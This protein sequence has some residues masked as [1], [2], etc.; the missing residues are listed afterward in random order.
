[1][2]N[3]YYRIFDIHM[4]HEVGQVQYYVCHIIVNGWTDAP[5]QIESLDYC[6]IA[7]IEAL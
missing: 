7:K 6:A 1:M 2:S 3:R 5:Y 4:K